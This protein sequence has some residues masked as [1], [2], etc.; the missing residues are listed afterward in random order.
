MVWQKWFIVHECSSNFTVL[1]QPANCA[2]AKLVCPSFLERMKR[3]SMQCKWHL[4]LPFKVKHGCAKCIYF[5]QFYPL[6]FPYHFFFCLDNFTDIFLI[7]SKHR[8][9]FM[10]NMC[11]LCHFGGKDMMHRNILLFFLA[12]SQAAD[13]QEQHVQSFVYYCNVF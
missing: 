11:P 9:F 4:D 12:L 5:R 6:S 8:T 2:F 7:T 13:C 10:Q 3:Q 1:H